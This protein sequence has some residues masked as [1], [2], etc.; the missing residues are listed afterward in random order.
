MKKILELYQNLL[1]DRKNSPWSRQSTIESRYEE[2][3][4][5]V[6]EIKEA[7]DKKDINNLKEEMGDV[8][9]DILS[10]MI[11]AEDTGLFKADE[12]TQYAIDKMKRRKPWIFSGEKLTI[13]EEKVRW[14]IA[15]ESE[16]KLT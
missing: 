2:L 3:L 5:E 9:W 16:K 4:S 14:K 10:L 15:K 11:I 7:I 12:S 13:E 8:L 1:I 6:K